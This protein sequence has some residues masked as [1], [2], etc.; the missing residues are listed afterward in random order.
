AEDGIRYWSVT[1]VQTCALPIYKE[2]R[3]IAANADAA[4]NRDS[5]CLHVIVIRRVRPLPGAVTRVRPSLRLVPV[6]ARDFMHGPSPRYLGRRTFS[7][8]AA[9]NKPKA[10]GRTA[11][12]SIRSAQAQSHSVS[13]RPSRSDRRRF[14]LE[15][16]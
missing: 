15:V 11:R 9:L 8:T 5:L 7:G 14:M 6:L 12:G 1:G 13:C 2:S 3:F 4:I 16:A 10:K